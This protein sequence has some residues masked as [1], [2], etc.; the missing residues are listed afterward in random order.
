[1]VTVQREARSLYHTCVGTEHILLGLL[2][3]K[4]SVAARVLAELGLGATETRREILKELDPNFGG[5][6]PPPP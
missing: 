2:W 4:D 1:L 6:E 5:S 3:E